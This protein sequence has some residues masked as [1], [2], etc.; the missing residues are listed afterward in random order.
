MLSNIGFK[1]CIAITFFLALY[2]VFYFTV[3][4]S[5]CSD[6]RKL[7]SGHGQDLTSWVDVAYKKYSPKELIDILEATSKRSLEP[8]LDFEKIGVSKR[9]YDMPAIGLGNI[10]VENI[11]NLS[12]WDDFHYI[13]FNVAPGNGVFVLISDEPKIKVGQ[14]L[15]SSGSQIVEMNERVAVFCD[16]NNGPL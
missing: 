13:A 7:A 15:L 6:A 11:L 10:L 3:T 2:Y 14:S 12:S 4:V 5:A 1:F 9:S 8:K 16:R